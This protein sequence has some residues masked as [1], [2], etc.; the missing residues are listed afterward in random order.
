MLSLLLVQ[1]Q[2]NQALLADRFL[3]DLFLP[4]LVCLHRIEV[5]AAAGKLVLSLGLVVAFPILAGESVRRQHL[6]SLLVQ[7]G[8]VL[9]LGRLV[10]L[11]F[12]LCEL[13]AAGGRLGLEGEVAVGLFLQ[14][15]LAFR[16]GL[17]YAADV[18]RL[19]HVKTVKL[20]ESVDNHSADFLLGHQHR[21]RGFISRH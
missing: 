17:E 12:V 7:L 4:F 2:N 13:R 1:V 14:L 8:D 11:I 5:F 9:P 10:F 20:P 16:G 18:G 3:P 15:L 21:P 19:A 6:L